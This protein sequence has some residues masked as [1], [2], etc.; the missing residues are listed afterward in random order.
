LT[1]LTGSSVFLVMSNTKT[2]FRVLST[3]L[4]PPKRTIWWSL[5]IPTYNRVRGMYSLL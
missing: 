2:S 3:L 1:L 5:T 4:W